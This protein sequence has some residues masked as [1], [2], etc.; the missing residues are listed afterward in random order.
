[1]LVYSFCVIVTG[2]GGGPPNP[3]GSRF[4]CKPMIDKGPHCL[5]LSMLDISLKLR[6]H[7]PMSPRRSYVHRA[8]VHVQIRDRY[9]FL[10]PALSAA[11]AEE[12]LKKKKEDAE[13]LRKE[14]DFRIFANLTQVQQGA[15]SWVHVAVRCAPGPHSSCVRKHYY[16]CLYIYMDPL[17][18][19]GRLYIDL[20][21][22]R[23]F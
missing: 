5:G 22:S 1:M 23:S 11:S 8:T 14:K 7:E 13:N 20:P 12:M 3:C 21:G 17:G 2:W 9:V 16:I 15:R 10:N 18:L 6:E 4:I 19:E